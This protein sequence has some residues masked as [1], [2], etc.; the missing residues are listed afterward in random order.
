MRKCRLL[1]LG[2]ASSQPHV[3]AASSH[4]YAQ[5]AFC[6]SLVVSHYAIVRGF[7]PTRTF[8]FL[9]IRP[10][11]RAGFTLAMHRENLSCHCFRILWCTVIKLRTLN[12][13]RYSYITASTNWGI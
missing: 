3:R 12:C 5:E 2:G 13:E 1:S 6:G 9:P 4:V 7:A 8:G 10:R 11:T